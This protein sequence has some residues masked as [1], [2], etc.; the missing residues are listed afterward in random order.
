[1]KKKNVSADKSFL[2]IMSVLFVVFACIC[3]AAGPGAKSA[4]TG[5]KGSDGLKGKLMCGYQGWFGYPGDEPGN[6]MGWLHWCIGGSS[7][8]PDTITFECWPDYSEYNPDTL[9]YSPYDWRLPNGERAGFFSSNTRETVLLH[10]KWMRDYGIDGIFLQRF[11]VSLGTYSLKARLDKVLDYI[12]EGAELYGLKV[13]LMYDVTGTTIQ[14][15]ASTIMRDW[16]EMVDGKGLTRHPAY[17]HQQDKNGEVLPLVAIWGIGFL[18]TGSKRQA[19]DILSFY[20]A[21]NPEYRATIMG[22]VPGYWRFGDRDSKAEYQSIYADFDIISPWTVGRF[23]DPKGVEGWRDEVMNGDMEV[24][25][26]R[27]QNYIPVC[28]PGFSNHNLKKNL[29]DKSYGQPITGRHWPI[30]SKR[31]KGELNEIPRMG[32]DFMWKQFYH[33]VGAGAEM[34]YVAMFDEVDEATAIFKVSPNP[35]RSP[36]TNIFLDLDIDGYPVRSDH[37][38][39]MTGSAAFLFKQGIPFPQQ[40]PQRYTEQLFRVE[41]VKGRAWLV[42]RH[43]GKINMDLTG[44][45]FETLTLFRKINDSDFVELKTYNKSELQAPFQL[46]DDTVNKTDEYTYLVVAVDGNGVAVGVSDRVRI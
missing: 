40:Q 38:L 20:K 29:L 22:G 25:A 31:L 37:Y 2:F 26:E 45:N 21:S 27:G 12:L 9:Y 8:N 6:T 7:P 39:W 14:R 16:K 3:G 44:L 13:V 15:I 36:G 24:I 17:M 34:L 28:F 43:Y 46:L 32:G 5:L 30:S 1:M 41:R 33:W 42:E 35:R 11:T 23:S 18:E 19:G 4:N 10:C